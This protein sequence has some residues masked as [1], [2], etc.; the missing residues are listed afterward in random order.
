M[1]ICYCAC[2]VLPICLLF[3]LQ[4]VESLTDAVQKSILEAQD[5]LEKE[6]E[7]KFFQDVSFQMTW[8]TSCF[9]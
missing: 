7:E 8:Q 1:T 2:D 6:R 4:F 9:A 3:F 5:K